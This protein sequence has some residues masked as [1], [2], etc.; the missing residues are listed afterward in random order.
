MSEGDIDWA[1]HFRENIAGDTFKYARDKWMY[2][3]PIWQVIQRRFPHGAR[4]LEF[5]TGTGIYASMLSHFGYEVTG[6]DLSEEMLAMARK[7]A[8]LLGTKNIRFERASILD[9]SDYYGRFDLAY[10]NGV[11]EH[12]YDA[13]AARVLREAA[14]C[15]P[16]VFALVPSH[17]V[18]HNTHPKPE[19]I[20]E[21][22]TVSRLRKVVRDAGLEIIEEVGF[23]AGN[24]VGRA[25]ELLCPPILAPR[26]FK[27]FASS[28][29][30]VARAR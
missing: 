29:G 17:Y 21:R 4:I 1:K 25:V 9:L 5:G 3:Q 22:Y 15:A 10:S 28:I 11:I 13:D 12:F 27:Y 30:V 26:I 14:K 19:G 8:E 18:W 16:E 23:S 2:N 6:V 24:K 20:F 7:N